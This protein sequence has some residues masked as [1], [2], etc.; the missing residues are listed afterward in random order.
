MATAAEEKDCALR[1]NSILKWKSLARC[2]ERA[3]TSIIRAAERRE[4]YYLYISIFVV[5]EL[6]SSAALRVTHT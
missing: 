3:H 1:K 6:Y 5:T 4:L 2:D